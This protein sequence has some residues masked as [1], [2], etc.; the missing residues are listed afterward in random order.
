MHPITRG[1]VISCVLMLCINDR[2]EVLSRKRAWLLRSEYVIH[3]LEAASPYTSH[4]ILKK[5]G[6]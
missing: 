1:L 6:A 4:K 3:L 5:D 2:S